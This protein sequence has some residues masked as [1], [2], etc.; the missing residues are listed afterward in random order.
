MNFNIPTIESLGNIEGKIVLLRLDLNV[1]IK[2][3]VI[4]DTYRIDQSISTIDVLRLKGAK[5]I[6]FA[7]SENKEDA[8]LHLVGDYLN[9]FV[10]LQF[11]K[12]FFTPESYEM[13]GGME[14]GDVILFENIRINPG[15]KASDPEFIKKLAAYGDIFVNE[16][17]SVS[18]RKHASIVGLPALLPHAAGPVFVNEVENLSK[19]FSSAHPFVFILGGAKFDTKMPLIQKFLKSADYIFVGGALANDVIKAQGHEVGVSIVSDGDFGIPALLEN[20]KFLVP[21]D[22]IVKKRMVLSS[23]KIS[24]PWRKTNISATSDLR[25]LRCLRKLLPMQ[26]LF[27]GMVP[28]VTTK[29]VFLRTRNVWRKSLRRVQL[30]RWWVGE[31]RWPRFSHS[32][33]FTNSLLF[34]RVGEPCWI[35]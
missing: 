23:R 6:I 5:V 16:A 9:G 8:S 17:F 7:H 10:K 3:G 20:K 24:M 33:C 12:T 15:E 22:V 1:P 29:E 32:T 25:R 28:S 35:F 4:T 34:R 30:S 18:H 26:S 19:A 27:C 21:V 13:V 14:N 2:D 11:C 31:I